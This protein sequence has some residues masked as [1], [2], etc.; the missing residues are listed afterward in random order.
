MQVV[1]DQDVRKISREF[2]IAGYDKVRIIYEPY[3][4]L[5]KLGGINRRIAQVI[6]LIL[7]NR[8]N[9][10]LGVVYL[11]CFILQSVSSSK[12]SMERKSEGR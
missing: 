2:G 4:R 5:G 11:S 6:K 1:E 3:L 7:L 10:V 8:T 12:K 9:R